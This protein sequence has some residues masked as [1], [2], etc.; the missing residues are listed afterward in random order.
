[1]I[2]LAEP[3]QEIVEQ[4]DDLQQQIDREIAELQDQFE[5]FEQQSDLNSSRSSVSIESNT[6][7]QSGPR[8]DQLSNIEPEDTNQLFSCNQL[9]LV[10]N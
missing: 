9:R 8:L 3:V 4:F 1:M 6:D 5:Q 10:K 7:S 2:R